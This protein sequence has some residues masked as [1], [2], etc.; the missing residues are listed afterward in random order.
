MRENNTSGPFCS[1]NFTG[2]ISIALLFLGL[3]FHIFI[4]KILVFNLRFANPRHIILFCLCLSDSLQLTVTAITITIKKAIYLQNGPHICM[5]LVTTIIFNT[6]LTCIV[7]SLTLVVLSIERYIACFHSYRI[8]EW[9]TN[10]RVV[11]A[12]VVVWICGV[13][14]GAVSCIPD[15]NKPKR[16]MLANSRH[17]QTMFIIVTFSVSFFL[18]FIQTMLFCLS[19]KKL[20]S[21]RSCSVASSNPDEVQSRRRGQI[22]GAIVSCVIV[23]SYLICMLPGACFLIINRYGDGSRESDL[24]LLLMIALGMLNTLLNPFIYGFGMMD[25]RK[26]MLKELRKIKTFVAMKLGLRNELAV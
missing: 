10:K 3:P 2:D 24:K 7:S 5:R 8:Q 25:T 14:G 20:N 18:I 19:R 12:L 13:I 9:L 17:F 15:S 4:I 21:L 1:L 23:L 26:A 16:V 22:K 6:I 11:V